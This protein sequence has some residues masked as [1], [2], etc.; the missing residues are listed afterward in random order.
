M[1][2]ARTALLAAVVLALGVWGVLRLF[3]NDERIIRTRL[4]TLAEKTSFGPR[5]GVLAKAAR[6]SQ[7]TDFFSAEATIRLAHAS[8]EE[9]DLN[10]RA[11]IS[12]ALTAAHT[13]LKG[14]RVEFP[15]ILV[16]VEPDK[17]SATALLTAKAEITGEKELY[18]HELKLTLK[19]VEREWLITSVED[20][21]TLEK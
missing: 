15:D 21:K 4:T 19:K 18:V 6:A 13:R 17:T 14:L 20:F 9:V 11:D 16:T 5:D 3:P 10:G 8:R 1:K 12:Q 7:V 2:N